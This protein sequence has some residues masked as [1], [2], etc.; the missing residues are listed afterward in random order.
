MPFGHKNS[1]DQM[2]YDLIDFI[3]LV[4]WTGREI[5]GDKK[6]FIN[7]SLPTLVSQLNITK[8]RWMDLTQNFERI[9]SDFASTREMLYLLA[10]QLGQEHLKGVG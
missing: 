9:F 1:K 4:D 10:D 6:G 3:N 7:N 5:R 8:K 2:C